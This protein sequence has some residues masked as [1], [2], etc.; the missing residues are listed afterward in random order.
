MRGMAGQHR[1]AAR[2]RHVADE[3]ARPAVH[4]R[5]VARQALDVVDED[6]QAP[7]AVAGEPHGLPV[8]AVGGKLHGA[9]HAAAAVEADGLRCEGGGER[10]GAEELFCGRLGGGRRGGEKRQNQCEADHARL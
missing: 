10:F 6:G 7:L 3:Q 2:L 1:A 8:G 9:G 5:R 4:G